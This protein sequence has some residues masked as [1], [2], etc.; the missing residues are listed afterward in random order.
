M[1][2]DA[3]LFYNRGS[4]SGE[5]VEGEEGGGVRRREE[6]VGL[7]NG[8]P[9]S[10]PGGKRGSANA[11]IIFE[12]I[13]AVAAASA[14]NRLQREKSSADFSSDGGTRQKGT[15]GLGWTCDW[16]INSHLWRARLTAT[17]LP[18]KVKSTA[19]NSH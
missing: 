10:L 9:G 4:L 18:V 19:F 1:L 14:K 8:N 17:S 16:L 2:A 7:K 11:I 3:L 6:G 15:R 12:N 13:A 5:K